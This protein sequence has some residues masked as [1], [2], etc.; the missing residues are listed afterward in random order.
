MNVKNCAIKKLTD[1]D[2]F[3]ELSFFSGLGRKAS[4]R[5]LNLSTVYKINR[6]EFIDILKL[7]KE[8]FERFKMIEE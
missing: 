3:G 1:N 4:A 8:D 5:S 6:N 7:C 2:F